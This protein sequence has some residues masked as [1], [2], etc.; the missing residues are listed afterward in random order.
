MSSIAISAVPGIE[1]FVGV[2]NDEVYLFKI[3]EHQ[4]N[5]EYVGFLTDFW[6]EIYEAKRYDILKLTIIDNEPNWK[7]E[8]TVEWTFPSGDILLYKNHMASRN[9]VVFR[10]WDGWTA[11]ANTV[12]SVDIIQNDT[13]YFGLESG[14]SDEATY[15]EFM[16]IYDKTTGV[17]VEDYFSFGGSD[18]NNP[19]WRYRLIRSDNAIFTTIETPSETSVEAASEISSQ[20]TSDKSTQVSSETSSNQDPDSSGDKTDNASV[21]GFY[22]FTPIIVFVIAIKTRKT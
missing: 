7:D 5:E 12:V 9:K 13:D 20:V 11:W 8:I 4:F 10:D 3:T 17:I 14:S 6:Y 15:D 19:H 18:L 16:Q 1:P 21:S 2:E 22:F